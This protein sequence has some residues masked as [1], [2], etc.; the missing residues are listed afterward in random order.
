MKLSQKVVTSMRHVTLASAIIF[1]TTSV[2]AH[3]SLQSATPVVNA[4]VTTQPT[5]L[6]LNFG[7]PVMLMGIQL[8][9]D[10]Q[11]NIV[12]NYKV[13]SEL[14][15]SYEVVIPKLVDSTYTVN[16]IIMGKD[17]HNMSGKYNFSLKQAK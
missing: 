13:T 9:D 2:F 14:K 11:N 5:K 10:K 12:L 8:V 1:A 3:T 6:V 4:T 7:E 17:G 16:W 15:K